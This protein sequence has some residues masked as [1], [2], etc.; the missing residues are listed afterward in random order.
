M[1][2]FSSDAA[3]VRYPKNHKFAEQLAGRFFVS[4]VSGRF[5][6]TR[7]RGAD[8]EERA[9]ADMIQAHETKTSNRLRKEKQIRQ[10]AR[11]IQELQNKLEEVGT[12]AQQRKASSYD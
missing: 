5:R 3:S 6:K 4:G 1:D 10:D 2:T 11:R 12:I 8:A 9:I 7:R